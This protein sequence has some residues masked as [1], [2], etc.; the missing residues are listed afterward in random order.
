MNTFY[1]W[2]FCLKNI[3]HIAYILENITI[4]IYRYGLTYIT[5]EYCLQ[6]MKYNLENLIHMQQI[7]SV[8]LF[9]ITSTMLL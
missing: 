3:I 2:K 8:T 4:S 9:F 6:N 5:Y 1:H 7:C